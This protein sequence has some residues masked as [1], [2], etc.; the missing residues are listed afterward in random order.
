[1]TVVNVSPAHVYIQKPLKII[2][3]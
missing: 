2:M 1:M 3:I